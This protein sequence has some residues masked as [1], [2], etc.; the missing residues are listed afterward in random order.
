MKQLAQSLAI[1]AILASTL[2]HAHAATFTPISDP[3][4]YLRASALSADGS[5][6]IGT[7]GLYTDG[8]FHWNR[9]TGLTLLP[10]IAPDSET[11][12]RLISADGSVVY[13]VIHSYDGVN[14]SNQA[15][16]WTA[17]TGLTMFGAP[18]SHPEFYPFAASSNGS[19]VAG[20][21]FTS[22]TI[23]AIRW[24]PAG[25]P[26]PLGF[27]PGWEN[28]TA[29]VIS[30]DGNVIGGFGSTSDSGEAFRW[31]A[32]AGMQP[33]GHL[34]PTDEI[35]SV[36]AMTPDGSVLAGNSGSSYAKDVPAFRWT[37]T[38]GMTPLSDHPA[39]PT[40]ISTDGSVIVG[41][42]GTQPE[43]LFRWTQPTGVVDLGVLDPNAP[44]DGH[45]FPTAMSADG[46]I[47]VG[48][49]NIPG[50]NAGFIW[51][52]QGGLRSI[53]E[54]LT[55]EMGL[56]LTGW[57]ITTADGITP[58][59]LTLAGSGEHNGQGEAWIATI[60]EPASFSLLTIGA[61]LISSF[62]GVKSK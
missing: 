25:G 29:V 17:S 38:G 42:L 39:Y 24:T 61:L 43:R 13:G 5:S 50:G 11:E 55:Q 9:S 21:S 58:D 49:A 10:Q 14:N 12:P 28:S 51:D 20:Y 37:S 22:P 8:A 33:L 36:T 18:Y 35:S 44:P 53:Q 40:L 15:Y 34:S 48:I 23:E 1:A 3:N 4:Q 57:T 45:V 46:S 6:I 59:G 26:Q 54:F 19:V 47:I 2:A 41:T 56:D 62:R 30:A 16:R 27:L 31:T 32:A 52:Q 60:P 7:T